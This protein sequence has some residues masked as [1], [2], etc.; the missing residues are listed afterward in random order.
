MRQLGITV[1]DRPEIPGK[2]LLVFEVWAA[3]KSGKMV[4]VHGLEEIVQ[5]RVLQLLPGQELRVRPTEAKTSK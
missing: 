1:Y 5:S 4:Q 2:P 3:D